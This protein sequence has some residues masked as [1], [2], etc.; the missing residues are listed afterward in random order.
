MSCLSSCFQ[1]VT[2]DPFEG[3]A[4][5]HC[6]ALFFQRLPLWWRGGQELHLDE[7]QIVALIGVGLSAAFVGSLLVLR[8]SAMLANSLAHTVLCGIVAAF[9]IEPYLY[10]RQSTLGGGLSLQTLWI[11][12]GLS[13]LLTSWL[14]DW[15]Q[16]RLLLAQETSVA[17]VFSSLFA[18]GVL[19]VSGLASE[20]HIGIEVI[21]GNADALQVP[22][23]YLALAVALLNALLTIP[24]LKEHSVAA[25]D[26]Q[27][28]RSAGLRTN[29]LDF[30]LV[31]QTSLTLMS[32]FRSVGSFL[33][34]AWLSGLPIIG[35]IWAR[36]LQQL[37]MLTSILAIALALASV[38]TT[39]HILSM[40]QI[41][42]STS[43]M[44]V[45][46][47]ATAQ[48]L[49][50]FLFRSLGLKT[51]RVPLKARSGS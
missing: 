35:L 36:S 33:A 10:G 40:H 37:W 47:L 22:D 6:L 21:M 34:L 11:A 29:I 8:R 50:M 23:A 31:I 43:G 1:M 7:I 15:V 24:L 28:A 20:A 5:W 16:R 14:T 32:A 19:L 4:G 39:R 42:L 48:L 13:A 44:S 51:K 38:C 45:A 27:F 12:A 46:L 30:L 17:L 2:A 9:F 41:P 18:L 3:V 25:F 49:L 26:P